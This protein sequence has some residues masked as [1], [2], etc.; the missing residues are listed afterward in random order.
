MMNKIRRQEKKLK[1]TNKTKRRERK[2]K[3]MKT[4]E[5]TFSLVFITTDFK[6]ITSI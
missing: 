2:R 1:K 3:G 4:N 6:K 5:H